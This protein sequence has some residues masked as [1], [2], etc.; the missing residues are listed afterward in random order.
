MRYLILGLLLLG[1]TVHAA[2]SARRCE[3]LCAWSTQHCQD[4]SSFAPQPKRCA[5][6]RGRIARCRARRVCSA[7]P[8][9]S[10]PPAASTTTTT[11]VPTTAIPT[12]TA[13]AT[14]TT[15]TGTTSTTTSTTLPDLTGWYAGTMYP[16]SVCLDDPGHTGYVAQPVAVTLHV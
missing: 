3:R 10:T 13:L 14:T 15:V 8:T 9:S 6:I 7:L 4:P 11:S 16:G 1:A 12:T 2:P 5:R